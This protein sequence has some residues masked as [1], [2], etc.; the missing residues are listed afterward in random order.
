M[1]DLDALILGL[2]SVGGSSKEE[3]APSF[4]D[5]HLTRAQRQAQRQAQI[6]SDKNSRVSVTS[7]S[8]SN[9]RSRSESRSNRNSRLTLPVDTS[10]ASM[11]A[12]NKRDS[13]TPLSGHERFSDMNGTWKNVLKAIKNNEGTD[14][15]MQDNRV[16]DQE[17]TLQTSHNSLFDGLEEEFSPVA[18]STLDFLKSPVDSAP[19]SGPICFSCND[20]ITGP[21]LLACGQQYHPEHFRCQAKVSAKRSRRSNMLVCGRPLATAVFFEKHGAVMCETCYSESSSAICKFCS[22]PIHDVYYHIS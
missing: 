14:R 18:T 13:T 22:E 19:S 20:H 1:D 9:E 5:K 17:V 7:I 11:D 10:Y 15:P 6:E 4:N 3:A 8:N 12:Q 2:S 21:S 16:N